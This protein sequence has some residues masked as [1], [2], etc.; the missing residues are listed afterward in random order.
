M[1]DK[2]TAKTFLA[3][4]L[5]WT[6]SLIF[7]TIDRDICAQFPWGTHFLWHTLN[8]WVLYRLLRVLIRTAK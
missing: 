5:V 4:V 1:R 3:I 6:G 7:R 2:A 8:A